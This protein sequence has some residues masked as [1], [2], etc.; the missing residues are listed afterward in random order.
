MRIHTFGLVFERALGQMPGFERLVG[1]FCG[2]PV[3]MR[4]RGHGCGFAAAGLETEG[5]C[6]CQ[7][8]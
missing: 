2:A 1:D 6:V 3:V 8:E 7:F 4:L 5:Q